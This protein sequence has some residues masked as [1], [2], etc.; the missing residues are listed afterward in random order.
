MGKQEVDLGRRSTEDIVVQFQDE[1]EW[2]RN[3]DTFL[4]TL[5]PKERQLVLLSAGNLDHAMLPEEMGISKQR[6]S[7]IRE[8][9]RQKALPIFGEKILDRTVPRTNK[10]K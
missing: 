3:L 10:Q 6:V 4:D 9:L 7:D 2:L 8:Q 1:S 5:T